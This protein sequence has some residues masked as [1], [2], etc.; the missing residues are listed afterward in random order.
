M[1]PPCFGTVLADLF[2]VIA[3]AGDNESKINETPRAHCSPVIATTSSGVAGSRSPTW[4]KK[5]RAAEEPTV[6]LE[7][8]AGGPAVRGMRRRVK[9]KR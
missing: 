8:D 1:A 6:F 7:Q 5:V 2:A 3:S 9:W 4:W